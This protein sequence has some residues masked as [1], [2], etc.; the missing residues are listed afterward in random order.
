MNGTPKLLPCPWC[1]CNARL[2]GGGQ[3]F[4]DDDGRTTTATAAVCNGDD[5]QAAGPFLA[6]AEQAAEAWNRMCRL[7]ATA[8]AMAKVCEA[9][10]ARMDTYDKGEDHTGG[11][12]SVEWDNLRA[13]L[14]ELERARKGDG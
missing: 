8:E 14:A 12:K 13:A 10:K 3:P 7:V 9:A 6:S 2:L 4:E 1:G 5:C 11:I